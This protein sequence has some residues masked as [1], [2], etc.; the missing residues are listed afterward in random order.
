MDYYQ[1]IELD[2]D[3]EV[4]EVLLDCHSKGSE[5]PMVEPCV[6]VRLANAFEFWEKDLEALLLLWI[7]LGKGIPYRSANFRPVAFN[8]TIVLR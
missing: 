7:S 1:E 5:F 3:D 6:K 8:R 2:S 4:S